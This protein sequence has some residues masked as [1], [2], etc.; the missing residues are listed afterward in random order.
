MFLSCAC[1]HTRPLRGIQGH[2][3][4][5]G[6]CSHGLR[7][8]GLIQHLADVSARFGRELVSSRHIGPYRVVTESITGHTLIVFYGGDKRCS[9]VDI[10][11]PRPLDL[12]DQADLNR[13][14]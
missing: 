9:C 5:F 7:L 4:E 10:S 2:D 1:I 6:R 12:N 3:V 8:C 13:D 14:L 11:L